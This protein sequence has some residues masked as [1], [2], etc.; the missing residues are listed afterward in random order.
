MEDQLFIKLGWVKDRILER[1]KGITSEALR[2][3]RREGKLVEGYHWRKADDGVI[4]YHYERID[5]YLGHGY[6]QAS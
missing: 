4:Y 5:E 6:K 3:K 2:S 1:L